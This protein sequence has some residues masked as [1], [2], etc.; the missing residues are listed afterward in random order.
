MT[1]LG[2]VINPTAGRGR[3]RTR[4]HQVIDVLTRRGHTVVNL[5]GPSIDQAAERARQGV[6]EGL[7]ALIV[8][9]GDGTM[10]LGANIVA[11]TSLPLGIVAAGSGNDL[12]RGLGLPRH[13][14]NRAVAAI[15]HGLTEGPR[16]ID[17]VQVG[18][19]SQA[20]REWY[21]G[22]LSAGLDAA[23]NARANAIR[24]PRGSAR[25]VRAVVSELRVF[26]PYGYRVTTDDGVWESLGT[27]VAAANGPLIG[28]GVRIAPAA[29]FDDGLLDVVVAGPFTRSG[30]LRIFPGMYLGRHVRH[31]AVEVIRTRSVLI[32]PTRHGA[33]PP[34]AFADGER[35]G[36]L[37]L[38]AEVHPGALRILV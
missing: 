1:R 25:Y 11:G 15:E 27:L 7:D 33:P 31:P 19:P 2:I 5:S 9:G 18:S 30:A 12:A 8:V 28:G 38:H 34:D 20:V 23:I 24:W 22:A 3:G 26:T 32:E 14:I 13:D 16:S 36:A 17:A 37:P 21:V 35:I 6:V 10:H 4:G 29:I